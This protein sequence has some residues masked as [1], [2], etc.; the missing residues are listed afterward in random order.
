MSSEKIIAIDI[1]SH[2]DHGSR[3]DRG[4]DEV[5]RTEIEHIKNM[6]EAAGIG[7]AFCSTFASVLSSEAVVSD[8][9]HNYSLC[10]ELDWMYQWVVIEPDISE[11]F[12]QAKAY[13][14]KQ[15]MCRNKDSSAQ[16]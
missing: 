13:A 5:H 10:Q 12:E 4:A 16:S 7:K 11:S 9:E 14:L 8:N 2:Y 15:K 3:F 6:Y 1:H